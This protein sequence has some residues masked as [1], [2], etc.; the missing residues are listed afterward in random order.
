[1]LTRPFSMLAGITVSTPC[2]SA[3]INLAAT[4]SFVSA[5]LEGVFASNH[6]SAECV[7]EN[8]HLCC[9]WCGRRG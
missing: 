7:F 3:C 5:V 2:D 4:A 1:M 9:R 8:T 6:A